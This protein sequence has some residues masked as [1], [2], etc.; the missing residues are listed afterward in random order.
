MKPCART[1]QDGNIDS[2]IL[3][4]SLAALKIDNTKRVPVGPG[5]KNDMGFNVQGFP[6]FRQ[7]AEDAVII[8]MARM[9]YL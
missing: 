6:A 8:A 5:W 7:K 3:Q 2:F 4:V 9:T 1:R